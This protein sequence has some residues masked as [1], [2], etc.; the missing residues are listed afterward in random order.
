MKPKKTKEF[1]WNVLL[2]DINH[3]CLESYD[4]VPYFVARLNEKPAEERPRT[5]KA[6]AEFLKSEAMYHFWSRCQYEIVVQGW[7]SGKGSEKIDVYDQLEMNW[8]SFVSQFWD[9][10]YKP[11]WL[12]KN[13]ENI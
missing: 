8:D 3:G 6:F 1:K 4:V 11:T 7:P 13:K 12:R 9:K 10:I 5:K 2:W